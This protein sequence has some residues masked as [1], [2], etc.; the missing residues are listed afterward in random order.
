MSD[1]DAKVQKLMDDVQKRRKKV[2]SLKKPQWLTSCSLQLPGHDRL[3][4]QV[5][6]DLSLLA[7]VCGTLNRMAAD[8]KSAAKELDVKIEP[9]WQNYP[10][11]DWVKDIKLRVRAT[12]IKT[13]QEKLSAMEAKLETLVSP[14]QRRA[15]E[16][17]KLEAELG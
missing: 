16:L 2:G 13:E 5:C 6:P 11:E 12:Q 8:I 15:M 10:I 7:Y 9:K 1:L 14:D 4:I 17:E 3:N